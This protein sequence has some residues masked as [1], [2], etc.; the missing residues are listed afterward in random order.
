MHLELSEEQFRRLVELVYLGN[1]MANAARDQSDRIVAYEELEQYILAHSRD[2]SAEDMVEYD[3]E[4][5][6][7]Y[8]RQ[9]V[10]D[11]L[12]RLVD[13]YEDESFWELLALR[14]AERDVMEEVGPVAAFTTTMHEK[15]WE[16]ADKYGEE[17][18]KYGLR[19]LRVVEGSQRRKHKQ[20]K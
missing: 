11:K 4:N 17:F 19:R 20:E 5:D 12:M 6:T 7:Y 8:V 1:W 9:D 10:E 2:F 13:E 15:R 18:E 16:L 14:L 3:E